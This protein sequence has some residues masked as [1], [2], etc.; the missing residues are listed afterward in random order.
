MGPQGPEGAQVMERGQDVD[1]DISSTQG[2]LLKLLKYPIS[3]KGLVSPP[4]PAPT[5]GLWVPKLLWLFPE[6]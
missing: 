1:S 3:E 2:W 4:A 5:Q 6:G